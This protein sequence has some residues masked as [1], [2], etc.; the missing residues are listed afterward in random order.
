MRPVSLGHLLED[1]DRPPAQEFGILGMVDEERQQPQNDIDLYDDE[2]VPTVVLIV[3]VTLA[4]LTV[5]LYMTVA[6]GHGHFH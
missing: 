5:V 3:I 2:E 6:G 1:G 4:V